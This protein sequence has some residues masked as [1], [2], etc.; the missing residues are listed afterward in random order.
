MSEHDF[1]RLISDS[2]PASITP[3]RLS[4]IALDGW[5]PPNATAAR[6]ATPREDIQVHVP[7]LDAY[8]QAANQR[9]RQ[10]VDAL[11]D[12][13]K[14][15]KLIGVGENH[16]T[17]PGMRTLV[18][19]A[20]PALKAAG[21]KYLAIEMNHKLQPQVDE[22]TATGK[23]DDPRMTEGAL[24]HPTYVA[25]LEEARRVGLKI[26][27]IDKQEHTAEES[28]DD[29]VVAARDECMTNHLLALRAKDPNAIILFYVGAYHLEDHAERDSTITA[30]RLELAGESIYTFG[31]RAIGERRLFNGTQAASA[32][33]KPTAVSTTD[34]QGLPDVPETVT[35]E[36][37]LLYFDEVIFFPAKQ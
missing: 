30:D 4:Q 9:G 19:D 32:V 14:N 8:D 21:L 20:L 31:Y 33:T 28:D 6:S 18:K 13:C 5:G 36:H 12:A 25:M 34:L 35:D 22:F 17:T 37:E 1:R 29:D 23:M 15:H 7:G 16:F 11:V 26:I 24:G 2:Q 3:Q 10:P 27:A